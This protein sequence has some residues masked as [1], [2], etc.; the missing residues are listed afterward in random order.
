MGEK[1]TDRDRVEQW[2]VTTPYGNFRLVFCE[3]KKVFDQWATVLA[4]ITGD[5]FNL[6]TL[7]GLFSPTSCAPI[8]LLYEVGEKE[9]PFWAA[10]EITHVAEY[11]HVKGQKREKI[12]EDEALATFIEHAMRSVEE[13]VGK[14]RKEWAPKN[15]KGGKK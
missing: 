8:V 4:G 5:T 13:C 2:T 15:K 12:T 6:K 3:T 11:L 7:R 1:K 9:L 14:T 10:H